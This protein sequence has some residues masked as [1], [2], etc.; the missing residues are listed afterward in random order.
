MKKQRARTPRSLRSEWF[1]LLWEV[2]ERE[3]GEG[4]TAMTEAEV[5]GSLSLLGVNGGGD[6]YAYNQ[7][8]SQDCLQLLSVTRLMLSKISGC[9]ICNWQRQFLLFFLAAVAAHFA[10]TVNVIS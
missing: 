4:V 10:I 1:R 2:S 6:N 7:Q 5:S 8:N 9:F 3:N